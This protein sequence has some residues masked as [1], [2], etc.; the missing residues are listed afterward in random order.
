VAASDYLVENGGEIDKEL[1][2]CNQELTNVGG[3]GL[4]DR[5]IVAGTPIVECLT[6]TVARAAALDAYVYWRY[7]KYLHH[8][9]VNM[10][11]TMSEGPVSNSYSDA[12]IAQIARELRERQETFDELMQPCNQAPVATTR[13]E[14]LTKSYSVSL[15]Y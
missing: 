7:A 6:D 14:E 1:M 5:W 15:E 2:P 10:P 13:R 3:T 9:I 11:K 8:R 4:I 12:Q